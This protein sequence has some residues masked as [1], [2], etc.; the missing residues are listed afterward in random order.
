MKTIFTLLIA[1]VGFTTTAQVTVE[2]KNVSVNG[3]HPG[4]YITIPYG[5]KKLIE[6]ELKDELKSW[7]GNYSNKDLI[8]VDDC[9]LKEVGDNTFDVYAKVEGLKEGGGTISLAIDLGG[10]YLDASEH[11]DKYKVI[12]ARLYKFAVQTAK[13]VIDI[14]VKE[15]EKKLKEKEKELED[16]KKEK[17]KKEKAIQD[18]QN[19][20]KKA[21]EEIKENEKS[22]E[23]KNKEIEE[24]KNKVKEVI[25]KKE[26]VK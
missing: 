7:K 3:S 16:L 21:E 15:E 13:N 1:F 17:E 24:Q 20:I 14:E 26:A 11:S 8:F 12:E 6:K 25:K 23:D 4:F 22:Q 5:N 9:K 2:S 10:A 19:E 18:W